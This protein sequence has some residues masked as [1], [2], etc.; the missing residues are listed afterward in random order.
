MWDLPGPAIE[1]ETP[2]L[3]SGFFTS[4]PPGKSCNSPKA[5]E[6]YGLSTRVLSKFVC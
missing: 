4:E 5:T 3:A 6:H 2:A 1:P